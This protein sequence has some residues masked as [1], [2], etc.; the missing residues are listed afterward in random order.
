MTSP[1]QKLFDDGAAPAAAPESRPRHARRRKKAEVPPSGQSRQRESRP[2]SE[3]V[4]DP[5][6]PSSERPER[7]DRKRSLLDE[8]IV[9][10]VLGEKLTF[11]LSVMSAQMQIADELWNDYGQRYPSHRE[12]F[13]D[14]VR[15]LGL[16]LDVFP[17]AQVYAN[18]V[19]ELLQ[20]VVDGESQAPATAAEV[21]SW[22]L[23]T[24]LESR[25]EPPRIA[26]ATRL[27][28]QIIGAAALPLAA[29][30]AVPVVEPAVVDATLSELRVELAQVSREVTASTGEVDG[31]HASGRES[32]TR[33]T[34]VEPA[35]A[36][37]VQSNP[38]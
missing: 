1:Q 3:S 23:K 11:L 17:N 18:H 34:A 36:G 8:P 16:C 32:P 35:D 10:E 25:L 26:L 38:T 20:R 5:G 14:C 21:L 19:R 2:E 22:L 28:D 9:R 31:D 6:S 29:R 12:K 15:G 33:Q 4:G 37:S 13:H 24:G 7:S 30:Q 27:F